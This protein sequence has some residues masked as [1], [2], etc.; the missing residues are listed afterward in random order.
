M[1]RKGVILQHDNTRPHSDKQTQEKMKCLNW[2]ILPHPPYLSDLAQTD[3][4]L[5]C[6][7]EHFISGKIFLN[8]DKVE[9]EFNSFISSKVVSFFKRGIGKLQSRWT[10]VISNDG[11]YFVE[12]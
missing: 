6:S 2:K 3:L 11:N 1:N 8:I 4:L 9:A 5:F 7:L 10:K 12:Q